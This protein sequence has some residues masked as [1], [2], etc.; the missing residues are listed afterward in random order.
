MP[1][2]NAS[3]CLPRLAQQAR[4]GAVSAGIEESVHGIA[5]SRIVLGLMSSRRKK[6]GAPVVSLER[7]VRNGIV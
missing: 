7:S 5:A 4:G 1:L 2:S 6:N 3:A